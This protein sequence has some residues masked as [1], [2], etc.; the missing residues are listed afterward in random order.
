MGNTEKKVD[1]WFTK[2]QKY[3]AAKISHFVAFTF[4]LVALGALMALIVASKWPNSAILT[5]IG[6]FAAALLAYY[7]RAFALGVMILMLALFFIL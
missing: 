4:I 2:L 1:V 5:V 7:N 6:P 3:A